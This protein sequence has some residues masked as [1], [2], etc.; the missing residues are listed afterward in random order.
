MDNEDQ[1]LEDSIFRI[2]TVVTVDGRTIR[3]KVDKTKN[4]SHLLYKGGA[5]GYL[6]GTGFMLSPPQWK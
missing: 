1:I 2:G 5:S 3:V 6:V 4:S